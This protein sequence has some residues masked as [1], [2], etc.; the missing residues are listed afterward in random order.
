MKTVY[1]KENCPGCIRLKAG[2]KEEGVSFREIQIGRDI[3]RE[4]FMAK[5]PNVRRVPYVTDDE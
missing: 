3:S 2:L 4:E 5:F 1:T